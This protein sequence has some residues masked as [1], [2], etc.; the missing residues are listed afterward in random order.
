M[1]LSK[2]AN[3]NNRISIKGTYNCELCNKLTRETGHGESEINNGYC[4]KCLLECY[5]ENALSD[6]GVDSPQYAEAKA[7][8]E[9]CA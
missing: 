7:N 5:M 1:E 2:M 3:Q 8:Y 9:A 4:K 6:Y